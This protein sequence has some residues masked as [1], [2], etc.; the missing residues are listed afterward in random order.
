MLKTFI[1]C[2]GVSIKV[3]RKLKNKSEFSFFF[4]LPIFLSVIF[5][6]HH[7]LGTTLFIFIFWE[8]KPKNGSF[9]EICIF[10]EESILALD[11]TF[12]SFGKWNVKRISVWLNSFY[13][14]GWVASWNAEKFCA[15]QQTKFASDFEWDMLEAFLSKYLEP[16]ILI[17]FA[18]K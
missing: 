11:C 14:L 13:S 6:D 7:F 10:V 18:I 17:A 9:C 12:F 15:F 3:K 1:S 4:Q 8:K 16:Q 2:E 5:F